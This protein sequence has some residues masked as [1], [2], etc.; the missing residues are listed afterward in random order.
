[1]ADLNTKFDL[2]TLAPGLR[3]YITSVNVALE[4]GH[5]FA[6]FA[7]WGLQGNKFKN[8]K[9]GSNLSGGN[10][11]LPMEVPRMASDPSA[12]VNIG[13]LKFGREFNL[14]ENVSP[15]R[16]ELGFQIIGAVTLKK[17]EQPQ[18]VGYQ[19]FITI[20]PTEWGR[21]QRPD[22]VQ[23]AYGFIGEP[24]KSM[25]ISVPSLR[26]TQDLQFDFVIDQK[27]KIGIAPKT[28]QTPLSMISGI[29]IDG[30]IETHRELGNM[31]IGSKVPGLVEAVNV[32]TAIGGNLR[33]KRHYRA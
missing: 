28:G 11:K 24:P 23:V 9:N 10:L 22:N 8:Q 29:L 32:G 4:S 33:R 17:G 5:F 21:I 30:I 16:I 7:G 12:P 14:G 31:A 26:D 27:L 19:G 25:L 13:R 20:T 18:K 6:E 1:M 2:G 3:F 15:G